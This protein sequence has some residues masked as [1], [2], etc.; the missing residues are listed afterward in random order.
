MMSLAP[1]DAALS[2]VDNGAPTLQAEKKVIQTGSLTLRVDSADRSVTD[3]TRIA[4]AAGGSVASSD[5]YD[6]G[7]G[8]KSGSVTVRVPAAR[9]AD[10]F[11][12]LKHVARLVVTESVS[13][14][15]VTEQVIDL[16]ARIKNK[17]AEESAYAAILQ[18]QTQKVSDILEVT[19]ALNQVR[20]EIES[21]QG[22]LKYLNSQA[23]FSTITISLSEDPRVGQTETWRPLQVV[24]DAANQLIVR[25]Q[26][27]VDFFIQLVII[28]LPTF[29]LYGLGLWVIY[30][31]GRGVYRKLRG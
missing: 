13:G 22:Q 11:G 25:L 16:G 14:T 3:V 31:I 26:A 10:V 15:D 1:G 28:V 29:A 12:Q 6:N 9:F 24:K 20:G 5:I 7:N 19:R 23:D 27:L 4:A 8:I 2:P 18:T 17:Q 30:L 21:L